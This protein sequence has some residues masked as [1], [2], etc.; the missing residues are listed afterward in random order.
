[1]KVG[2]NQPCPCGSGD[3]YKRCC[4]GKENRRNSLL[5]K[6]L[7]V[8]VLLV[9]VATIVGVLIQVRSSDAPASSSRRVWDPE[10]GHY[11]T[12]G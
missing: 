4:A 6:G 10:H 12:V 8:V 2:R 11:H 7:A 3:K 1:M 9:I 5:T